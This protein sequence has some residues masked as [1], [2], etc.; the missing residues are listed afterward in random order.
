MKNLESV[1]NHLDFLKYN[2]GIVTPKGP[3]T[4]VESEKPEF[5]FGYQSSWNA[6][7]DKSVLNLKQVYLFKDSDHLIAEA[8]HMGFQQS[9]SITHMSFNQRK[10]IEDNLRTDLKIMKV[11]DEKEIDIFS[12][13]QCRAFLTSDAAYT[14]WA[15]WLKKM[16]R[17]SITNPSQR[18]LVAYL[19]QAP[20]AVTLEVIREN[21]VGIYA[22]ATHPEYQR[23]GASRTLL[24]Y[25]INS[26]PEKIICLQVQTSSRAH[27]FYSNL[28]FQNTLE[29]SIL[30]KAP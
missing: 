23:R 15:P 30:G 12:E 25:T 24:N 13:I 18:Y 28:G 7:L 6:I 16:N 10:N 4:L 26:Y 21:S 14:A 29:I 11:Q 1:F 22:V 2:R 9:N 19:G 5:T 3:F 17:L 27:I 20:I 8:M